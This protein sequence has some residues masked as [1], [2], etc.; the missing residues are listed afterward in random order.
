MSARTKLV[1]ALAYDSFGGLAT[2]QDITSAEALL[3]EYRNEVLAE[4]GFGAGEKDTCGS[5]PR[6]GESTHRGPCEYPEVLPCQCSPRPR[7]LPDVSTERALE[8]RRVAAFFVGVRWYGG[9]KTVGGA[10]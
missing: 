3:D 1:R 5:A 4:A 10:A 2:E 9:A 7:V 8:R 6:T